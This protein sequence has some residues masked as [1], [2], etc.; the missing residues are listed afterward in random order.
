[1][2]EEKEERVK[3]TLAVSAKEDLM[4]DIDQVNNKN[5]RK[6]NMRRRG[7]VSH[8]SSESLG[9]DFDEDYDDEGITVG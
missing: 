8:E 6:N 5:S 9:N 1:M 2:A 7:N 4:L 3:L